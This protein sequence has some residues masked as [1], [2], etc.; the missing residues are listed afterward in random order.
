MP[1]RSFGYELDNPAW[2]DFLHEKQIKVYYWT[3]NDP[4]T[5]RALWKKGADGIISDDP[6]MVGKVLGRT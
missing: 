6:G 4:E 2:I 5:V 1:L 3:I